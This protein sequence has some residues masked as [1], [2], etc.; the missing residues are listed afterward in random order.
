MQTKNYTILL[1]W[2]IVIYFCGPV[3]TAIFVGAPVLGRYVFPENALPETFM[4][5][6]YFMALLVADK[7]FGISQIIESSLSHPVMRRLAR[8][9]A[10]L[11]LFVSTA[12]L[13]AVLQ[14]KLLHENG[15]VLSGSYVA[16]GNE[17][18][19]NPFWGFLAGL[20]EIIFLLFVLFLNSDNRGLKLRVF[21]IATYC[22]T[23]V[24]RLAGGTR[25]IL[26]KELAFMI[27]LFYLRGHLKRRQLV[28]AVA[29]VVIAG[30]A[31]GLLRQK[32]IGETEALLGPVYG[33]VMESALDSLT[34]NIAYQVQDTGYVARQG[35]ML[36]TSQ[37]L[38]LS[39]IPGFLRHSISQAELDAL[40]PYKTAL[41][42]GYDT[43]TPVGGMSGFATLCYICSYPM[44]AA[45]ILAMTIGVL[46]RYTPAGNLKRII[47]LVFLL[48]AIHFWRDPMDIAVKQ[49][50]QDVLC[51]LVLLAV[52]STRLQPSA[53]PVAAK[54]DILIAGRT[55]D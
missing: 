19:D 27:I 42:Y 51:T 9:P 8:S 34:L 45:I 37:F 28:T 25:L 12:A 50:A 47:V 23:T 16:A 6:L 17:N 4:I 2:P 20:Y 43:S 53:Q 13:A 54:K 7:L 33:L 24:L 32:E 1:V 11:P 15:S 40:S 44:T 52:G 49:M 38:V 22:L 55:Q 31:L 46:F 29:V 18:G 48:N 39:S 30:S 5:F 35:N 3:F 41:D 36:K 21:M 14:I 26:I 10:F